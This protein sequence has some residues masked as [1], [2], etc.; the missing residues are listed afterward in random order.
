MLLY[1]YRSPIT[2]FSLKNSTCNTAKIFTEN[3]L[4]YAK[5]STLNDPYEAHVEFDFSACEE[6]AQISHLRVLRERN[7]LNGNNMETL[8]QTWE[9]VQ[10]N[11]KNQMEHIK[12]Q[13]LDFHRYY[14]D[15]MDKNGILSLSEQRN[16]LL[17]WAHYAS[18]HKGLCLGFNWDETGLPPSKEVAYLSTYRLVDIWAYTEDELVEIACFQKSAEWSYER[19]WRS[20]S[21]A[22][23]ERYSELQLTEKAKEEITKAEAEGNDWLVKSIRE[24]HTYG[25]RRPATVGHRALAFNKDALKEVIFGGRMKQEDVKQHMKFIRSQGYAP[26][27]YRTVRDQRRYALTLTELS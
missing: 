1:K 21:H 12:N 20:F 26:Q 19:E 9:Q 25:Y 22:T 24:A 17:M 23:Y 27:F 15:G 4:Y 5:P 3:A 14:R 10:R 2:D 18:D 7:R 8:R 13:T 16:N 6:K 11:V